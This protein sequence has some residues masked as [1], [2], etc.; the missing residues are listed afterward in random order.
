MSSVT[1][2]AET[3]KFVQHV[4]NEISSLLTIP[5]IPLGP[6]YSVMDDESIQNNLILYRIKNKF[7]I[8]KS[9]D[10][11][12]RKKQTLSNAIDY[13]QNGHDFWDAWKNTNSPEIK[14]VLYE[15]RTELRDSLN[16]YVFR[17]GS[18]EITTG[19]TLVSSRGDTSLLAKLRDQ[20]QWCVTPDCFDLFAAVCYRNRALKRQAKWHYYNTFNEHKEKF[21]QMLTYECDNDRRLIRSGRKYFER[22][23]RMETK[24]LYLEAKGL[25]SNNIGF[26]VF[27]K[28]LRKVVTF[29]GGA[30]FTT[31]PKNN[32]TDRV[33]ECEAMCNMVVQRVIAAGIRD[34]L[35][36]RYDVDLE[37]S[38]SVHKSMIKRWFDQVSTIDLKNA[39]NSV[40]MSTVRWLF[41]DTKLLR[42]V[43][44]SR[45]GHI[46]CDDE[47]YNLNM[48][49]PMG[50]GFTFELMTLMLLSICRVLDKKSRVFGDDIIIAQDKA[51]LLIDVLSVCGFQANT[52]KTFI[53]GN[54]RE[55]CG[56]FVSR[57]RNFLSY[58]FHYA[59]DLFDA[60][61][62]VN[63]LNNL[64][65][66]ATDATKHELARV[67]QN[68]VKHAPPL[69]LC[70]Y[71]GKHVPLEGHIYINNMRLF[72]R[73]RA[74]EKEDIRLRTKVLSRYSSL[75]RDLQYTQDDVQ[76]CI[77]VSKKST[78]YSGRPR[79]HVTT[80]HWLSYYIYSGR[81]NQ[82]TYGRIECLTKVGIIIGY[83]A[84][85]IR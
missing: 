37:H 31:V 57:D 41:R 53:T 59:E 72:K 36:Q 58:D 77:Q 48:V 45:S 8:P 84:N 16:S 75:L 52:T 83:S 56:G 29:V 54:F 74:K 10:S 26:A 82:P 15:A 22:R 81:V 47:W 38:Q 50:N 28:M 5:C 14:R 3:R 61:V 11:K 44:S 1:A 32:V 63:K 30:R 40:W 27:K 43:L 6:D 12:L 65:K 79:T 2:Y 9:L 71:H 85:F 13:D 4:N 17:V 78:C 67:Y 66:V 51:H 18:C 23:I 35:L 33:I 20:K 55:S 70:G 25:N 68:I 69:L 46:T 62:L 24:S 64:V 21:L 60:V 7:E 73:L 42:H 34:V 39:S 19:E 80:P 49:A 76:V